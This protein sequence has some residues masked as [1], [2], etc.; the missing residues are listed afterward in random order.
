[1]RDSSTWRRADAG[2]SPVS[3]T[4]RGCPAVGEGFMTPTLR[5][6]ASGWK[7]AVLLGVSRLVAAVFYLAYVNLA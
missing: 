5:S 4:V 2:L 7:G 1:M 3:T 6:L